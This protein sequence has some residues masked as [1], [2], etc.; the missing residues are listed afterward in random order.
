MTP[1]RI[2][3]TTQNGYCM[4]QV[5]QRQHEF[6]PQPPRRC[7]NKGALVVLGTATRVCLCR[8]H[9]SMIDRY[10]WELAHG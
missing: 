6:R 2:A 8:H 7:D 4:A 1:V 10:G 9:Q 3:I 5:R